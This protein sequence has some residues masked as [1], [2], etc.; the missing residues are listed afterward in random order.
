MD[1]VVFFHPDEWTFGQPLHASQLIGRALSVTGVG[2][3]LSVSMRRWNAG[4]GPTTSTITL[5]PGDLPENIIDTLE[6]RPHEIIRIANDPN[7]LEHGR[8]LF[9]IQGGRQ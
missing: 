2:R 7:H 1:G 5:A 9:D 6:V 8:I 4:L 3:V